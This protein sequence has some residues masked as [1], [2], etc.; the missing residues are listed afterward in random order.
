MVEGLVKIKIPLK[1]RVFMWCVLENK[2]PT[3]DNLQK[4]CFQ[5]PGWCALCHDDGE[6]V[7]HVFVCCAYITEVWRECQKV[8]G[9]ACNW[10][11]IS[12]LRDWESWRR[13]ETL[14]SMTA[15]PLL[16]I[17]GVWLAINKIIFLDKLVTPSITANQVCGILSTFPQHIR[18]IRQR[19]NMELE[20]DHSVPWGFFYGASQN[21]ICGGGVILFLSEHHFFELMVGLGDGSNNFA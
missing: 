17:W 5:G 2:V 21:N 19:E 18:V 10:T 1:T 4:R 15:L 12:I 7:S 9:R 20:L 11:G 8:L 13:L 14:D 16:V 6:F 3:W